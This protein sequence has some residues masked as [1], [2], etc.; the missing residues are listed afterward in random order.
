MYSEENENVRSVFVKKTQV[1]RKKR[2]DLKESDS[3][4]KMYPIK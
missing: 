2:D 4:N 1:Y 3:E